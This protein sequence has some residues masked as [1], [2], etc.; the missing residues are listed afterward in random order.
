MKNPS[1][2]TQPFW[3][4]VQ[5]GRLLLQYDAA[6]RRWQFYPRPVSLFGEGPVEWK[7]SA[8]RGA[9]VAFTTCHAPARGFEADVPYQVGI[10]AL[11]EGVR[12][13]A[14]IRNPAGRALAV[15]QRMRLAWAPLQDGRLPCEF[16]PTG[17]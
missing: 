2:T 4:G 16:E 3:D 8:G 10:V 5:Q 7:E 11:D 1:R 14:R 13:F 15:G 6:A 9:L 17:E 12:L